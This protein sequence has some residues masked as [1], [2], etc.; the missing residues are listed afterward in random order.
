MIS[1]RNVF[2]L[3]IAG[4]IVLLT[5]ACAITPEANLAES[6][7]I[8]YHSADIVQQAAVNALVL[9]GF[10]I[11]KKEKHY[12]QGNRPLKPGLIVSS[13]GETVG[14]WIA[15]L[16]PDKTQV[17]V[18]TTKTFIGYAG[19]KSWGNEILYKITKELSGK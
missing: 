12:L 1:L 11:N 9:T 15:A 4:I 5:S 16:E 7:D 6:R 18:H 3:L 10:N 8:F 14:I 17:K 19:Q 2:Q 13:G